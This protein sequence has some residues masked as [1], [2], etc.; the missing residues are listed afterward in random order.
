MSE[1]QSEK[2]PEPMT[3]NSVI[4]RHLAL[5]TAVIV[6]FAALTWPVRRIALA[7]G[8][9]RWARRAGNAL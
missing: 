4:I 7:A 3:N 5:P 9:T 6:V 1:H 8:G 2:V